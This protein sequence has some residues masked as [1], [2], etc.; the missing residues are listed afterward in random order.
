MNDYEYELIGESIWSTYQS[1]AYLLM[2]EAKTAM[3]HAKRI[4][5]KQSDREGRTRG[6]WPLQP[7]GKP[8]A[9][10]DTA[11]D[12]RE[13]REAQAKKLKGVVG[14]IARKTIGHQ[15]LLRRRKTR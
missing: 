1:M 2:G 13:T 15:G 9:A 8:L 14:T 3:D 12:R 7:T 6:V 10:F 11:F 5:D 4:A